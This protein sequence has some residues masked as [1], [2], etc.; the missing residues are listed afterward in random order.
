MSF[1]ANLPVGVGDVA[2]QPTL[3]EVVSSEEVEALLP[4]A[5]RYVLA[6]HWVAGRPTRVNLW[7]HNRF[8]EWYFGV[9]KLAV[10]WYHLQTHGTT[11]VDKFYG[12][13]R[14][15]AVEGTPLTRV[16]R[17]A[18]MLQKIV[19]PYVEEKLQRYGEVGLLGQ[20]VPLATR[21]IRLLDLLWKLRY[22]QGDPCS[23]GILDYLFRIRRTRLATSSAD[24]GNMEPSSSRLPRSNWYSVAGQWARGAGTVGNAA[25]YS[26]SQLFPLFIF[27]LKV[28]QWLQ[29]HA[30][31]QRGSQGD[32][33]TVPAPGP[34]KM[35]TAPMTSG[36][37]V[38]RD[39]V[40]NACVLETGVVVCYPCALA[41]VSS[42]EGKCP[43]TGKQLLGCT[44]DD[45]GQWTFRDGLRKLL[46]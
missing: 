2:A 43:V 31:Q 41:Y 10:E 23:A 37:P 17:I 38:C 19:V 40:R 3:F 33:D 26:C 46:I 36:C 9:V 12:L 8:D 29:D 11:F 16:Q 30:D 18:V 25:L 42:H 6:R 15:S 4:R 20:W 7:L 35:S 39:E 27:S 44:L 13:G 28:Y 1:Y 14:A 45:E 24:S 22:L 32:E 34:F 5:L 21:L